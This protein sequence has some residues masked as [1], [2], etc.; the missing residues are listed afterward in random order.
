MVQV[1]GSYLGKAVG[2]CSQRRSSFTIHIIC[3][4]VALSHLLNK[5]GEN[6]RRRIP[7]PKAVRSLEKV[8]DVDHKRRARLLGRCLGR[9]TVTCRIQDPYVRKTFGAM[10]EPT[11][12]GHVVLGRY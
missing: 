11:T 4:T 6:S 1:A 3:H 2:E 8:G 7:I 12:L 9:T 10:A 5:H